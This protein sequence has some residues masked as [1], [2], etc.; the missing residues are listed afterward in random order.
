MNE[1]ESP[2]F[3]VKQN[4]IHDVARTVFMEKR[5]FGHIDG[6]S[7]AQLLANMDRW[8]A[9]HRCRVSMTQAI[10]QLEL[11][12]ALASAQKAA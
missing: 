11:Q 6:A 9:E 2:K 5:L 12:F 1:A 4:V 3:I 7:F 8:F 10:E